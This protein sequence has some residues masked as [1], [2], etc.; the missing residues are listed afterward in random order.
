VGDE[1]ITQPSERLLQIVQVAMGHRRRATHQR[2]PCLA[3]ITRPLAARG[4][5]RAQRA[6]KPLA[7]GQAVAVPGGL[8]EARQG[9]VTRRAA[10]GKLEEPS[11]AVDLSLSGCHLRC[12]RQGANA[13][14]GRLAPRDLSLVQIDHLV[15]LLGDRRKPDQELLGFGRRHAREARFAVLQRLE[16]GSPGLHPRFSLTDQLLGPIRAGQIASQ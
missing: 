10:Q 4:H 1:R 6:A 14:G 13:V 5:R 9:L 16:A 3:A 7:T 8:L 15:G 11:G 2:T 12:A